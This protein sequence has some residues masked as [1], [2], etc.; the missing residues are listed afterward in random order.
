MKANSG[1]GLYPPFTVLARLLA[2]SNAEEKAEQAAER[3]EEQAGKLL[4]DHPEWKRRVLTML[5]D[6]PSVKF[7]KGKHRRHILIKALVS[8]ET[9]ALFGALT[10]LAAEGAEGAEVWF[11]VNPN[12][13]M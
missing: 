13:M 5:R 11:E 7:L 6:T 9:D 10:E 8:R 2:E 12:T 3:L 4:D 1:A